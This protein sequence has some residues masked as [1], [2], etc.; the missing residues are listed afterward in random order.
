MLE[1]HLHSILLWLLW[2]W[3]SL[4]LYDWADLEPRSTLGTQSPKYL[5]LQV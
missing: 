2:R 5:G 4:E 3:G 1:P